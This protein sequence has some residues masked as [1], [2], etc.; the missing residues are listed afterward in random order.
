VT[1]IRPAALDAFVAFV[2]DECGG[3]L[4]DPRV[5]QRYEPF[6]LAYETRVDPSFDP[7]GPD[8]FAAQLKLYQ[9]IAGRPLDQ[10]TGELHPVEIDSLLDAPNPQGILD[11]R[12][13]SENVRALSSMLSMAC[14]PSRARILDMG[15]G[16]GM[17]SE[18]FA[19]S[20]ARVLAVDIDR[21]LSTLAEAR[22]KRRALD[23]RRA[24]MSFDSLAGI[25]PRSADAAFF[26]QSLHHALR[27]WQL[28]EDLAEKVTPEGVIGFCG[29]PVHDAVWKHWGLRLDIESVY[30]ARKFGWFE[31]GW[32][33]TFIECCFRRM[34]WTLLL[35]RGGHQGGLTGLAARSPEKL[36]EIALRAF[37][38]GVRT[39]DE[40]RPIADNRGFA[41]Q[42]G[43]LSWQGSIG[44]ILRARDGHPGGFL[45]FGPYAGLS[46]GRYR[47]RF[48]L[49]MLSS[50]ETSN[51][52]AP[53]RLTI[54]VV[55]G[56]GT[57][58]HL[59]EQVAL[60]AADGP[61][62]IDLA[63]ELTRDEVQ[64]EAR[65]FVPN[66]GVVWEMSLPQFV[67]VDGVDLTS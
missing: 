11:V 15:A 2:D 37:Q 4:R 61:V 56:T 33:R 47:V 35:F 34:G 32:S 50:P 63:F 45:C 7:F 6:E 18:V 17:S 60:R 48:I 5:I 24:V 44:P 40:A 58:T 25:D 53:P 20:G 57:N 27:P 43:N 64:L 19:F 66:A 55:S 51:C 28:L 1:T 16:H 22:A 41:S 8:Y 21:N 67:S 52:A 14:L 29:E 46:R 10:W 38:L 23:I 59:V 26:F 54:D 42:I 62:A 12:H 3:N 9:E 30:V 36:S 31:S 39:A 65:A 13:V 49:R